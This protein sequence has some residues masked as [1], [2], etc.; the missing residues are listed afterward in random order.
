MPG[1]TELVHHKIN[2][3]AQDFCSQSHLDIH[4]NSPC[5]K[6]SGVESPGQLVGLIQQL[7]P[8]VDN[9]KVLPFAAAYADGYDSLT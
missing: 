4:S 9:T 3:L 1:W 5:R 6:Y 7:K 2:T 8:E